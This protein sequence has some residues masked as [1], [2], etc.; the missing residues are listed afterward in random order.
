MANK[1][2]LTRKEAATDQKDGVHSFVGGKPALPADFDVPCCQLCGARQTFF[3]QVSFPDGHRWSGLTLAV[4]ACTSCA[5][6][7]SSIP[8]MLDGPLYNAIIPEGF[9]DFYQR[10]FCL[11][12]FDSSKGIRRND[13]VEKIKYVPLSMAPADSAS[14]DDSGVGGSPV[15]LLDDES[16]ASYAGKA[17]MHFLLQLS[18]GMRFHLL[19]SA[20][21]QME[22]GLR[23]LPEPSPFRYYQL[24]NGNLIYFFGAKADERHLV[25]AL[26]QI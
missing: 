11:Y 17:N 10:N 15:W 8:Q 5:T 18:S 14:I 20:P 12:V 23:G 26:T 3:F 13:Y 2:V 6:E 19:D 21:P 25:Y 9:L 16:P 7:D 22:I 24:F 4:F 1:W